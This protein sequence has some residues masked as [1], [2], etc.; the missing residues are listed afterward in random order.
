MKNTKFFIVLLAVL[1]CSTTFGQ[2]KKYDNKW[3]GGA[4]GG[5]NF[6]TDGFNRSIREISHL[7]AGTAI[8]AWVGKRLNDQFGLAVGYQGLN[9]S[10]R[11]VEYGQF[12]FN[13][14]HADAM[15][16]GSRY[17]MPYL[18]AGYIKIDKGTPA[19]GVGVK[20]PIPV[21]ETVSIVPDVKV[22]AYGD[23]AYLGSKGLAANVSATLGIA[24]NLARPHKKKVVEPIYIA[25]EPQPQPEP[26]PVI[27]PEP[28]P[29]PAPEPDTLVQISEEFTAKIAGI[30]LFDFDK[31]NIRPEA[32]PV[33]DEIAQWLIDNPERSALIEGYTDD[34]G[35]DAYNMVL[36]Q[37]RA[38]S[39]LNYL[40][41][42]GVAKER[43]EAVGH[44][45]GKFTEGDTLSEVRQ[46][47]RRVVITLK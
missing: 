13:Y 19:G 18:H 12:P 22:T 24:I 39:V 17:F 9:I 35:T 25:P 4:G 21:S 46:Q 11:Y 14:I 2:E 32:F 29:Q 20:V 10:K 8:D 3:F 6:G 5:M 28:E 43:L 47:N 26:E 45:K 37:R 31:F 40:V 1:C 41:G 36:S 38:D 30:T 44:G 34:R 42:K 23:R 15:F 16:M 27:V 33:L 7:G